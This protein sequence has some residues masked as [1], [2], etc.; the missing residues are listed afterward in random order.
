MCVAGAARATAKACRR[1]LGWDNGTAGVPQANAS[2]VRDKG[3]T[4][5]QQCA[6][7]LGPRPQPRDKSPCCVILGSDALYGAPLCIHCRK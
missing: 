3:T 7:A 2:V 1:F 5:I 6:P 4:S